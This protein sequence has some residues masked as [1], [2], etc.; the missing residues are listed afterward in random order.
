MR[1]GGVLRVVCH[2]EST[3]GC[4]VVVRLLRNRHRSAVELGN[5]PVLRHIVRL[6]VLHG[7]HGTRSDIGGGGR[8]HWL[9]PGRHGLARVVSRPMHWSWPVARLLLRE[10]VHHCAHMV[11]A[12]A[13]AHWQLLCHVVRRRRCMPPAP[14]MARVL[15]LR[16]KGRLPVRD[17]IVPCVPSHPIRFHA[18]WSSASSWG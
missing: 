7:G 13:S 5:M 17:R 6:L 15:V 8:V 2:V 11:K 14:D 1:Q 9:R 10:G 4:R 16:R 12:A 18:G 3:R